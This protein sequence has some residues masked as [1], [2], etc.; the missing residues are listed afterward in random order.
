LVAGKAPD[1]VGI[2]AGSKRYDEMHRPLGPGSEGG[3]RQQRGGGQRAQRC[4]DGAA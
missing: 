4:N 2:T 1:D 3:T